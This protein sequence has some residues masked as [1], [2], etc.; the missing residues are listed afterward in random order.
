MKY[1]SENGGSFILV[2]TDLADLGEKLL[3]KLKLC[4]RET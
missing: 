4:W 3:T 2:E 1:S